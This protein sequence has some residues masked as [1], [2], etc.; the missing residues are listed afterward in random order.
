TA[1]IEVQGV[2]NGIGTSQ[3]PILIAPSDYAESTASLTLQ[4]NEDTASLHLEHVQAWNLTVSAA[5]GPE[6]ATALLRNCRLVK[7]APEP[8]PHAG[9]QTT[10]TVEQSSFAQAAGDTAINLIEQAQANLHSS[11]IHPSGIALMLHAEASASLDH[12]TIA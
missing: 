6:A 10:L 3:S 9:N 4:I 12:V 1:S 2:F 8:I 7:S 5:T 11:L